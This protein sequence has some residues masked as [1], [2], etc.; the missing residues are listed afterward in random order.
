MSFPGGRNAGKSKL[1]GAAGLLPDLWD[2]SEMKEEEEKNSKWMEKKHKS[3]E[4]A[5]GCQ[6]GRLILLVGN[7]KPLPR[8]LWPMFPT[9]PSLI[10]HIM[11]LIDV[12]KMENPWY[13]WNIG[14]HQPGE[15]CI[16]TSSSR[17]VWDRLSR[18]SG[19]KKVSACP[20]WACSSFYFF[21]KPLNTL[22]LH[23]VRFQ[24]D[25]RY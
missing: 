3:G 25:I 22:K 10:N 2:F 11:Y 9:I 21:A 7:S 24:L 4:R 19:I 15:T 17:C 12:S 18:N 6:L 23:Q 8:S 1:S 5:G 14:L 16:C 13:R 20:W